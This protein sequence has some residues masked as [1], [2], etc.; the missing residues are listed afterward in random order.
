MSKLA[1]VYVAVRAKSAPLVR[2]L[3]K[4][5]TVMLR[6]VGA[7]ARKVGGMMRR[8]FRIGPLAKLGAIVGVGILTKSVVTFEDAMI[9]LRANMRLLGDQGAGDFK[10]LEAAA[11]KMGATTRFTATQAAQALNNLALGGLNVEEAIATLPKV[12]EMA[13]AA[14]LELDNAALTLVDTMQKWGM[15]AEETSKITDFLV[16]GQLQ[17]QT[18]TSELAEA[19][20]A[21]Q[22]IAAGV[23][24]TLQDTM[25]VLTLMA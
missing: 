4:I 14:G 9:S 12:L 2:D 1:E 20:R 22:G 11:R 19:L 13:A 17:A 7:L 23:N 16:S 5:K 3:T 18:T 21:L 15:S 25:A 8:M 10:R 6:T 24:I